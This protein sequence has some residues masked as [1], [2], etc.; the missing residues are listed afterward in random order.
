MKHIS[1]IM[2]AVCKEHGITMNQGKEMKIAEIIEKVKGLR[3]SDHHVC[4]HDERERVCRRDAEYLKSLSREREYYELYEP[5]DHESIGRIELAINE[6]HLE[7]DAMD[8]TCTCERYDEIMDALADI[9]DFLD[10]E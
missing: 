1:E 3:D 10:K 4:P 6:I 8:N 9:K 7:Q 5:D 2:T